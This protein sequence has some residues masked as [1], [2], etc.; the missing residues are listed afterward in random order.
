MAHEETNP[1]ETRHPGAHGGLEQA[2]A[3]AVREA[4]LVQLDGGRPT[5]AVLDAVARA[6]R[7]ARDAGVSPERLLSALDAELARAPAADGELRARIAAL[8][9]R[10]LVGGDD[11]ADGDGRA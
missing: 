2:L 11:D 4:A 6:G 7:S 9:L 1:N 3:D 5:P 10:A 8:L